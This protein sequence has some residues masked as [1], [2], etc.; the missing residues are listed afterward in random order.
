MD[1]VYYDKNKN[2][3]LREFNYIPDRKSIHKF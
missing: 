1:I 3:H 2:K